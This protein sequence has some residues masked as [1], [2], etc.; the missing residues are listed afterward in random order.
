MAL[1]K[2]R[3]TIVKNYLVQQGVPAKQLVVVGRG[4][5]S[6]CADNKKAEGRS[7]NRRVELKVVK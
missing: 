5:A 4:A 1:S 6:P 2:R 7:L 3:A